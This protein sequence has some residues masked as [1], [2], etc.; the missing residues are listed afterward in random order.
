MT[1]KISLVKVIEIRFENKYPHATYKWMKRY[2]T[3][4]P[5]AA[6]YAD[7]RIDEWE[8]KKFCTP[9]G[10]AA[11]HNMT[12]ADNRYRTKLHDRFER[13]AKRHFTRLLSE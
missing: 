9:E 3:P 13:M 6:A 8:T 7:Q 1:T 4:A 11:Y 12:E 5:A 10:G 2:G